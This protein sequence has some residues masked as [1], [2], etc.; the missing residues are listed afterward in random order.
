MYRTLFGILGA[1]A[2]ALVVVGLT[3]SGSAE[4]RADY[5]WINH[6]EPKTLDPQ[7]MTG[8]PEGQ[9]A[10]AIFEGLTYNDAKTLTPKPGSAASWD[11]SPD[12]LRWTFHMRPEA[13]WSNGGPV[14]AHDFVF[15]WVRLQ[16][17]KT[18]SE[19]A[20]LMHVVRH[21]EAYNTY[22]SHI[23]VLRGNP[24]AEEAL[25]REG[26]LAGFD[27]VIR[28]HPDGLSAADWQAFA[29]PQKDPDD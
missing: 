1:I 21:A 27:R 25:A 23:Q 10:D 8:Q 3:F 13:R 4:D 18:A 28:D 12:G 7:R 19:Y 22:A 9:V 29:A 5:A 2:V 14:T 24:K 17:P 6:T 16:E 20:Y 11:V 15:A 26:I